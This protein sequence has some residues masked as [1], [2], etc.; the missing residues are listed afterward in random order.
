VTSA[1]LFDND[2]RRSDSRQVKIREDVY[3]IQ[4]IYKIPG[5]LVRVTV[6]QAEGILHNVHLSGDFFFYP[7]ERLP[8]LEKALHGVQADQASAA[9]AIEEF[10]R[11]QAIESP[12]VQPADLAPAIIPVIP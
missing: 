7:A 10:Y 9:R 6:T 8:D 4:N 5:G 2:R 1:W 3:V 11:V 12:G